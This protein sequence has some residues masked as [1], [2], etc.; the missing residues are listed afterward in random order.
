[1]APIVRMRK[2][3][4][5]KE[6]EKFQKRGYLECRVDGKFYFIDKIPLLNKKRLHSIDIV[7]DKV[8]VERKSLLRTKSAIELAKRYADGFFVLYD[9]ELGD[10]K[11]YGEQGI[12]AKCGSLLPE[13]EP[14]LF[15]FNSVV[16]ACPRCKG[17]GRL[18]EEGDY[19]Y[20]Y[21]DVDEVCPKCNGSRL[22]KE[23]AAARINGVTIMELCSWEAAEVYKFIKDIKLSGAK[24][25]VA[26][27]ILKEIRSKL[28]F[29]NDVGLGYLALGR[30]VDTLSV[31]EIQRVRLASQIG[32]EMRGVLYV[33][34][35]PTI[36][37]HPA[38]NEMLL[39][40]L[41]ILKNKGNSIIV[42]EHDE[43]TIRSA[44]YI[45]DLG[46]GAGT[47]GGNIVDAGNFKRFL[48]GE[49]LTA[50]YLRGERKIEV[51]K[52]RRK[53]RDVLEV[54]GA[55]EHNLKNINLRVPLGIFNVVTGVSG[56]GKSTLVIDVIYKYLHSKIYGSELKV[57]KVEKILGWQK[58]KRVVLVDQSPIG[59]TPRS[60]PAT[61]ISVWT[62]IREFFSKLPE[63]RKL[64]YGISRFSYNTK[65]GRCAAC[66][67]LGRKKISM[68]FL[69]DSYVTCEDCEGL[70][71]NKETL[72]V[73]Y[74]GRNI[75]GVLNLTVKEAYEVFSFHPEIKKKLQFL[76]DTSL[77]YIRLGQPSPSLSGGEA[78]RIKLAKE[79]W[80]SDKG[81]TLYIL[82]EPTTGLH[83][84]DVRYLI[85]ALQKLVDKG[86]TVLVI[87]HNLDVIKSADY[88]IDLGPGAG[89]RGGEVVPSGTPE[90]VPNLGKELTAE[91]KKKH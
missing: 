12:C 48:K 15:S 81:N 32:S 71:F 25:E 22:R 66:E 38:D 83:F 90:E 24:K 30:A 31:G 75:A 86:N 55:C 36:G 91:L 80:R 9:A 78:Q 60:V 58:I 76:I 39:K 33:L 51:P 7:I 28:G 41:K 77:G 63:S 73:E 26:E 46:P 50:K 89:P 6:L 14:K 17:L 13:I 23:A 61:Y 69:P 53:Y 43:A 82:D 85:Q 4:H 3:E 37:L 59:R 40:M 35:E 2:G 10:S 42:V 56:S 74:R 20:V 68:T 47:E 11:L 16:G 52:H 1:M 64:G 57:G 8:K 88:V 79:L 45:I 84:E 29:I 72:L 34:D 62:P 87:E 49:S 44:D 19:E 54:V 21:G 18:I 67:G 70:R 27:V 5:R 65:A